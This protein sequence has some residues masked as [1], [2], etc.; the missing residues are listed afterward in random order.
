[1]LLE[2]GVTL[3]VGLASLYVWLVRTLRVRSANRVAVL[4][5]PSHRAS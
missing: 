5:T 2:L 4:H 3:I 1:M